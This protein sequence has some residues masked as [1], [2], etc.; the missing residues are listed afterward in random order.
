MQS[1]PRLRR[2][3]TP[4]LNK[5]IPVRPHPKQAAFLCLSQREA[6]YG[7]AAGGGKSVALLAAALQYVH[8]PT[9]N[10]IILRRTFAEL[11]L[12]DSIMD[13]ARQWLTGTDA[14]GKDGGKVWRFPSGAT[15]TFGYLDKAHDHQRYQGPQFQFVGLDEATHIRPY[16]Q[17]YMFSRMRSV[18]PSIPMRMRLATNPGG[19]YHAYYRDRF[20]REAAGTG[21]IYLPAT[22]A[23]NPSLDRDQYLANLD[24]LD[25][26]TRSQLAEGNWDVEHGSG[27]IKPESIEWVKPHDVP[28]L[29]RTVRFWDCAATEPHD[30]NQ[31]PDWTVGMLVGVDAS[32]G[33]WVLDVVRCRLNPGGVESLV[34]RTALEDGEGV[35]QWFEQ[36]P[37]SAGKAMIA[38][39][40]NTLTRSVVRSV[41][42]TGPKEERFRPLTG[43]A[44]RGQL[45]FV[46]SANTRESAR[47]ICKFPDSNYHDDDA[48][49]LSGA[50][51]VL[52][53]ASNWDYGD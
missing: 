12:P 37:G 28:R 34:V 30:G 26:V 31:D 27:W 17:T 21:R 18:D 9:Y 44:R 16:H 45:N 2:I 36:E 15:L 25:D 43:D 22:I 53:S 14:R 29:T 13:L 33:L 41:R 51:G 40:V 8:R 52:K 24:E 46:E 32:G 7:G 38:H 19:P 49:A 48:D 6:L 47:L 11:A 5:Y 35:A 20:I 4:R 42:P 3:L 23:D 1:S 39:W 50:R 10:A